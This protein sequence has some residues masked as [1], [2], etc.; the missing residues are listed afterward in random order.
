MPFVTPSGHEFSFYD[1][2]ENERLVVRHTSGSHIEFK[3]DG[4]VFIKAVKDIHTH[5]SVLSAQSNSNGA[6]A[7]TQRIDTDLNLEIGGKLRIRCDE[8]DLEVGS[9]GRV[10][11]GTDFM[12]QG[13]N[14]VTKATE[15]ISLEGTKSI[16]VD[17]KEM[18]ERVVSRQTEAGTMEDGSQGGLN[19]MNVYGNTII[20]NNDE[21]GGIT[22]ASKGYL[23]LVAGAERVDLIGQF[24]DTPSSEAKGTFTTIVKQSS[25]SMD[26][27]TM[28]GDYVFESDAGASYTY[29]KSSGGSSESQQ[30][31]LK[32]EVQ[33]GDETHE[34]T[35]GDKTHNVTAGRLEETVGQNRQRTVGGNELVN[36]SGTQTV[37]AE[38]IFL[39]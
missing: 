11:A 22:I 32:I 39:N 35:I 7:T 14:V 26:V 16:Y 1:T 6:E 24:T 13:N 29:A 23:N 4:S 20:Q 28:P 27:S 5:S 30:D 12:I 17:T 38:K 18:R 31:G 8:L 37:N 9:T 25:G 34:V 10:Y 2:P 21:N 15:S 3:A 19:V 36:I 33:Q